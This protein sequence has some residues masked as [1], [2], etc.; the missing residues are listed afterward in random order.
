M[1]DAWYFAYGSNMDPARQKARTESVRAPRRAR[2]VD[3]R[4]AFNK[5]GRDGTAK[6]NIFA[7][8]GCV[9]WGVAYLCSTDAMV[10][11]DLAE[12]VHLAQYERTQTVIH[13]DEGPPLPAITYVALPECVR[14]GLRPTER[15]LDHILKGADQHRL[16]AEYVQALRTLAGL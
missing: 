8:P 15:Y 10:A 7:E 4:I 13:P 2:L 16:P 14:D 11:L 9:V 12:G 1:P 6:A 3:H 5:L